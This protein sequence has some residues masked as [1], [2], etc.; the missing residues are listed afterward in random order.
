MA[1]CPSPELSVT[2]ADEALFELLGI[3]KLTL[4]PDDEEKNENNEHENESESSPACTTALTPPLNCHRPQTPHS[5]LLI[6]TSSHLLSP[7]QCHYIIYNL[8][9]RATNNG[10]KSYGPNYITKAAHPISNENGSGSTSSAIVELLDP[11]HHKV[12]V[13]TSDLVMKWIENAFESAGVHEALETWCRANHI[14]DQGD[15]D[16]KI[17]YRINPRLRLLRYDARDNDIFLSHY[18]ATTTSSATGTTLESKITI[19]LYLNNGGGVD[20]CGGNTLF[21]N[22]L[23]PLDRQQR[24]EVV[25]HCG[26]FVL[27]NHELYHASQA[28]ECNDELICDDIPGGTKFVLRSDIMFAP[29]R[30]VSHDS[31]IFSAL[32][33]APTKSVLMVQD[34]LNAGDQ[35]SA[36]RNHVHLLNVLKQLDMDHLPVTSFLVPGPAVVKSMLVDL[37]LDPEVANSFVTRCCQEV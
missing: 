16:K 2:S 3:N 11:N 25:P 15:D 26:K 1:T 23:Q 24:Q 22:A 20:F 29:P 30:V 9:Y 14:E 18:D 21:L 37:G 10:G 12:C 7:A 13:F 27:F 32:D 4:D 34:V 19:L 17:S 28:L 33:D 8:G 31:S 35:G 5:P 36:S 6:E